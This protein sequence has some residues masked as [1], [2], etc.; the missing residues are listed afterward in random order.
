M[1]I[2]RWNKLIQMPYESGDPRGRRLMK[3]ILRPL[4][5]RR[6]KETKDKHGRLLSTLVPL[7]TLAIT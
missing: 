4:M 7:N 1:A 3:A 6:T 2:C 5:L